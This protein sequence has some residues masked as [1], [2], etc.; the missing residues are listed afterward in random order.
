[1]LLQHLGNDWDRGIDR[2]GD[3]ADTRLRAVF[4]N[5]GGE[6]ANNTGVD[7]KQ[8]VPSHAFGMLVEFLVYSSSVDSIVRM[9][10]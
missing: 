2:V 10:Y 8:V 1:M 7:I 3:D 6:G 9:Q 4:G 5:A